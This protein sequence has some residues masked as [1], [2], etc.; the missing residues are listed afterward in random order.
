[1]FESTTLKKEEKILFLNNK[2]NEIKKENFEL[3]NKTIIYN[4]KY[5]ENYDKMNKLNNISINNSLTDLNEKLKHIQK[6]KH[7]DN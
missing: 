5:Q 4:I 7:S 3:K 2:I 1:M 6:Q